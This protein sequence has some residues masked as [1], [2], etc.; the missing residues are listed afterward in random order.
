M[1]KIIMEPRNIFVDSQRSVI[2]LDR[3]R[4]RLNKSQDDAK[5]I[6]ILVRNLA[7]KNPLLPLVGASIPGLAAAI[8]S[9]DRQSRILS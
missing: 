9:K 7:I 5:I 6:K 2:M 4:G 8:L 3:S 1:T